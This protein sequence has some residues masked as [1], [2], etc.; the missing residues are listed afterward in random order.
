MLSLK[1]K[2]RGAQL[3][4]LG[5]YNC[6]IK[7]YI[8]YKKNAWREEEPDV[9]TGKKQE[10]QLHIYKSFLLY[11][12][13]KHGNTKR[14]GSKRRTLLAFK[15]VFELVCAAGIVQ[16]RMFSGFNTAANFTTEEGNEKCRKRNQTWDGRKT[17]PWKE[18][19]AEEIG[20]REERETRKKERKNETLKR[21]K[22][23]SAREEEEKG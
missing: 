9:L 23:K 20:K 18:E 12:R 19:T 7:T 8:S 10:Y 21:K 16:I 13:M 4:T 11:S 1:V 17:A 2:E 5:N 15:S 3:L 14:R 22:R 6:E